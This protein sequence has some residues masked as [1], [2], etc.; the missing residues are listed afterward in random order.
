MPA[1][2]PRELVDAIS[3]A[4]QESGYSAALTSPMRIH[5]RRFIVTSSDGDSTALWVYAWTLTFGGRPS[6]PDEYRIQMTTVASPLAM[7][8][9]GPTILIGYEPDS[10]MFAG[11]DLRRHATFTTGSPSVQID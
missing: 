7:N 3:D 10:G 8:P 9:N 5:P 2:R 4:I 1:I 11:F 6:L